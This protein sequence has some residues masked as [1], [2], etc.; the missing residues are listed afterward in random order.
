MRFCFL[1]PEYRRITLVLCGILFLGSQRLA[2]SANLLQDP[3]FEDG[4]PRAVEPQDG[5]P[6][7]NRPW[8]GEEPGVVR[9]VRGTARTGSQSALMQ[10]GSQAQLYQRFPTTPSTEYTAT[11]WIKAD[12]ALGVGGDSPA[13]SIRRTD[14]ICPVEQCDDDGD[15]DLDRSEAIARIPLQVQTT[16]WEPLTVTFNAGPFTQLAIH[17]YSVLSDNQFILVDDCSVYAGASP[18]PVCGDQG[19]NDDKDYTSPPTDSSPGGACTERYGGQNG[20]QLCFETSTEC[21]FEAVKD[22]VQSCDDVCRAGGGQ[23]LRV[24]GNDSSNPCVALS[25]PSCAQTARYDDICVC[26]L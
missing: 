18:S 12:P 25:A 3:S 14:V 4:P 2:L 20:F 6:G 8:G 7:V 17:L 24:Y 16:E 10:A 1:L 23:C 26:S 19:C 9:I 11:C 21:G 22:S 5:F 15:E 13:L